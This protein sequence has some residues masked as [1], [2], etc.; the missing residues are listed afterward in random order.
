MRIIIIQLTSCE[1][2]RYTEGAG[3]QFISSS[4]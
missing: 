1:A 3:F 2:G 4:G